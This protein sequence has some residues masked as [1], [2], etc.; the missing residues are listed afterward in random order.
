[1][2]ETA[3]I[4][5][6]VMDLLNAPVADEVQG[7]SMLP[8]L[9]EESDKNRYI[10][11]ET[12]Y[13]AF[14]FGWS[15]LG[16]IRSKYWKYIQAPKPE[17]YRIIEDEK[18]EVDLSAQEPERLKAMQQVF[19]AQMGKMKEKGGKG[20]AR[21]VVMD[22]QL[23]ERLKW[24]GYEW[25]KEMHPGEEGK[26]PKDMIPILKSYNTARSLMARGKR[27][28]GV[29][30]LESILQRDPENFKAL[31]RLGSTYFQ[32]KNAERALHFLQA[33]VKAN[34]QYSDVF[35]ML[36]FLFS[37]QGALEKAI[38]AFKQA[39]AI[40]PLF[41][42]PVSNIGAIYD[43]M[44]KPDEAEKWYRKAL[45]LQS[46]FADARVNL[47]RLYVRQ[48]R[49][50]EAEEEIDRA[51][52]LKTGNVNYLLMLGNFY[53]MLNKK[54]KALFRKRVQVIA[55][56]DS[57][58]IFWRKPKRGENCSSY[59]YWGHSSPLWAPSIFCT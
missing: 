2:V 24:L 57:G 34:P 10:L 36:G 23:R 30:M 16:G 18:E 58:G 47:I 44:N 52:E 37:E 35:M 53:H 3:D 17:L 4:R 26:D 55:W 33:A 39:S 42:E 45:S 49:F 5:P 46:S 1:M 43:R 22:R 20:Y 50:R 31:Y 11:L 6:T 48:K 41:T 15:S 9:E 27:D 25:S 12:N 14:H 40:K 32:E 38:E 19:D 28:H 29:E 59:I 56:G 13:P 8:L 51:A 21:Q 7:K 54:E